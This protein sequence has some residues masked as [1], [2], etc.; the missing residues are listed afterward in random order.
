[1]TEF[2]KKNENLFDVNKNFEF[3][4]DLNNFNAK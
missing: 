1:M 3:N 2:N 4:K